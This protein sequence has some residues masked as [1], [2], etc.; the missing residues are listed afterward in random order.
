MHEAERLAA[1]VEELV[2]VVEA[3]R[4]IDHD[5]EPDREWQRA[6]LTAGLGLHQL[7]QRRAVDVLE[8][9]IVVA[10]VHARIEHGDEVRM[11]QLAADPRLA[12]QRRG[13]ARD[14]RAGARAGA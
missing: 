9:E 12:L 7:A 13:D 8:D 3:A 5:A 6:H 10:V 2:C 14:R 4:D 1:I 11:A